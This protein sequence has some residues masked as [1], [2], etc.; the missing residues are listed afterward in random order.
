[1][2]PSVT[3]IIIHATLFYYTAETSIF[4]L[5]FLSCVVLQGDDAES[6]QV[7]VWAEEANTALLL[8]CHNQI[9]YPSPSPSPSPNL[10]YAEDK[11]TK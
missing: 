3:S 2:L 5:F 10:V 4:Y 9:K 1:M 6:H 11:I 7:R 8:D